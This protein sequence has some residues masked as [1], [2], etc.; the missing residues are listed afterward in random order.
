MTEFGAVGEDD[1]S[2]EPL[3]K[4]LGARYSYH[5][6]ADMDTEMYEVDYYPRG[7][8]LILDDISAESDPKRKAAVLLLRDRLLTIARHRSLRIWST[9]HLFNNY[10]ITAKLRN[11]A[12]WIYVFPRSI[13]K[14]FL[15]ILEHTFSWKRSKRMALLKKVQQ[16]GRVCVFS[17]QFPQFLCT[18]KR[19][20]LL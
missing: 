20:I 19:L 11:C 9:E 4:K 8:C 2:Y 10:R 6:T 14:T 3:Q 12:R 15:D 16:D 1:P 5:N 17:K 13:P 18:S 7:S